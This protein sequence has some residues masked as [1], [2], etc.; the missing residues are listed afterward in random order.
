MRWRKARAWQETEKGSLAD[1]KSFDIRAKVSSIF[2]VR[3]EQ[4]FKMKVKCRNIISPITKENLGESSPW[5]TR[6]K[7]YVVLAIEMNLET[8]INILIQ[9]DHYNDPVFIALDGFEV[10]EQNIPSNWSKKYERN[11]SCYFMPES[12]MYSTFY[13]ELED[14]AEKAMFFFKKESELIYREEG[15]I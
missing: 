13:E 11:S 3:K 15:L 6:D 1:P 14:Q 9:T 4:L 5:L 12:W 2:T 10:I 7:E 8:G